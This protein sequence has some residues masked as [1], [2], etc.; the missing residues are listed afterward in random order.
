[1]EALGPQ[2]SSARLLLRRWREADLAPF[3]AINADPVVMEHFPATLSASESAA[4]IGRIET[5]FEQRG[6]GLWAVERIEGSELI[7]FVGLNPVP[8][9]LPFAPAVEVGWRLGRDFWGQG[10]ATEAAT[11]AIEF[12][13]GALGLKQIVSFT[14]GANKRSRRVMER[15]GMS[16]DPSE[17][18]EHPL[19]PAGSRLRAHVLYRL[20]RSE[21]RGGIPNEFA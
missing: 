5:C 18:F 15:L 20:R 9:E 13:F 19:L 3:A 2:L 17:D 16:H 6:Y 21:V 10:Y 14:A 8:H 11:A 12:G 4:L 7:G 1:M